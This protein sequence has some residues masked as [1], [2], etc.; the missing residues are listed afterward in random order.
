MQSPNSPSDEFI[1]II[2][3]ENTTIEHSEKINYAIC[4]VRN[5]IGP[6]VL[7]SSVRQTYILQ[8]YISEKARET[9]KEKPCC[10]S[11][12]T[13]VECWTGALQVQ[14]RFRNTQ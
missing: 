13:L 10:P 5:E 6:G 12:Y 11:G 2:N 7:Q 14:P 9:L 8:I 3:G 4:A 1:D